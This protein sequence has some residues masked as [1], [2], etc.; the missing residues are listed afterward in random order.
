M[1]F[2]TLNTI[3]CNVMSEPATLQDFRPEKDLSLF[4]V[5]HR[6]ATDFV[7]LI[8]TKPNVKGVQTRLKCRNVLA[9]IGWQKSNIELRVVR[10]LLLRDL[11]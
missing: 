1:I 6:M 4:D 5:S 8:F 11:V 10:V 7:G 2:G 9:V 3:L